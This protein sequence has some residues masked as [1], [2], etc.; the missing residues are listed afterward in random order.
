MKATIH[1]GRMYRRKKRVSANIVGSAVRPRI[2]V[3]RSS[4]HM[5][6]QAIDDSARVTLC[7]VH[8]K[9]AE[10]AKKSD[11]AFAVGKKLAELLKAKNITQA[12]F[13]RGANTYLGRVQKLAEG[14][15]DGGIQV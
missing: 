5:Y 10:K 4:K 3:Y 6:A 7:S 9:Q 14:L 8:T 2:S 11:Q 15:R 1:T 13:D 12:V